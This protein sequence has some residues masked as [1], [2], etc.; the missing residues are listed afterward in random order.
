VLI[1]RGELE[2]GG[3]A[4]ADPLPQARVSVIPDCGHVSNMEQPHAFN[5]A[6]RR[7]LRSATR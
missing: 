4:I 7:F 6:L 5:T 1:I 3:F 2:T